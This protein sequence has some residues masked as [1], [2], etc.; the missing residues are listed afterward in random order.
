[1]AKEW[2]CRCGKTWDGKAYRTAK[3]SIHMQDGDIW[4]NLNPSV[5]TCPSCDLEETNWTYVEAEFDKETQW[6]ILDGKCL[7]WRS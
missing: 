7:P 6:K 4:I 2:I 3:G 1:M 5:H